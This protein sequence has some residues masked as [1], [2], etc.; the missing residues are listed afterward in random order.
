MDSQPSKSS[1]IVADSLLCTSPPTINGAVAMSRPHSFTSNSQFQTTNPSSQSASRLPV[2]RIKTAINPIAYSTKRVSNVRNLAQSLPDNDYFDVEADDEGENSG[3]R[4]CNDVPFDDE[5]DLDYQVIM[6]DGSKVKRAVSL[7]SVLSPPFIDALRPASSPSNTNV[8]IAPLL[9]NDSD[10]DNNADGISHPNITRRGRWIWNHVGDWMTLTPRKKNILKC[11]LAY[12][13]ASLFTFIPQLHALVGFSSHLAANATVFFKPMN[14]IGGITEAAGIGLIY[15]AC[16]VLVCIFSMVTAVYFNDHDQLLLGHLVT[17]IFWLGGSTFII[18]YLKARFDRPTVN[19][20]SSLACIILFIVLVK[21]GSWT[22]GQFTL[23]AIVGISSAVGAGA[24]ISIGVCRIVWPVHATEKLKKDINT[25]LNSFRILLKLLVK[26]FLLEL[27][28]QPLDSKNALASELKENRATFTALNKSLAEARLEFTN[29]AERRKMND[30]AEVVRSLQQLSNYMGGLRAS[31]GLQEKILK[32]RRPRRD[33]ESPSSSESSSEDEEDASSS[34]EPESETTGASSKKPTVNGDGEEAEEE[35]EEGTRLLFDFLR[36]VGGPMKAL[37]YTCKRTIVQLQVAIN[38]GDKHRGLSSFLPNHHSSQPEFSV[39]SFT[40]LKQNL[41]SALFLFEQEQRRE[42][43]KLYKRKW[44]YNRKAENIARP[45]EYVF[46]VYF[47]VFNLQEFAREL[48]QM[49]TKVEML[50]KNDDSQSTLYLSDE[51]GDS[52]TGHTYTPAPHPSIWRRAAG[53]ILPGCCSR[54]T[55]NYTPLRRH[56]WSDGI[57]QLRKRHG[58]ALIPANVTEQHWFQPMERNTMDTLHTP[59][60]R[61]VW[62]RFLLNIWSWLSYLRQFEVLFAFKCSVTAI[63]AAVPAFL[64]STRPIFREYRGEWAIITL[65]VVMTPTVGGTNLAAMYRVFGTL[66]GCYSAVIIYSLFPD[67]PVVLSLF[68]FLFA[69]P[70]FYVNLYTSHQKMG[71]FTLLAYNLVCLTKYNNREAEEEVEVELIAWRRF[72]AVSLGV[73]C[74]LLVTNYVWPYEARRELRKGLSEF[75][76]RIAWLYSK[77]V[78]VYSAP[79]A[80]LRSLSAFVDALEEHEDGESEA[81]SHHRRRR[82]R[83]HQIDLE[84]ARAALTRPTITDFVEMELALHRDLLRLFDLLALTPGEPR[85]KGP[86]PVSTYSQMLTSCQNI[87]DKLLCIRV[88]VTR[89]EWFL[90]VRRDFIIPVNKER[91]EM[92]GNVLLYLYVLSSAL[93]LKTP[94]PPYL[95]PARQSWRK[96]IHRIRSLPVVKKRVLLHDDQHYIFYYAYAVA[97]RDVIRELDNLGVKMGELFGVSPVKFDA[98]FGGED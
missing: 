96:L 92:V 49:I 75:L 32:G 48:L 82:R 37:A 38:T 5:E 84:T 2:R 9:T 47:Y 72:V 4:D 17:L 63:L 39:A 69:I 71:Q 61:T 60:P 89:E 25:S 31:C 90:S 58:S 16:A 21:E 50:F 23:K 22:L 40:K 93:H 51:E 10:S 7:S 18:S 1:N 41:K 66:I 33:S 56:N 73:V 80:P 59:L 67:N 36:H 52:E 54:S 81:R 26:T 29:C 78:S 6:D 79:S 91:K 86:F 65:M 42:V 11:A 98:Y 46:L 53:C 68:G 35:V 97:M 95:P 12:F 28:Y 15:G 77:L 55:Q 27:P 70:C 20:A 3:S 30:Y 85:L 62:R 13:L 14:T 19:T 74:G 64:H 44:R 87:L 76:H 43:A 83:R 24:L 88:V 8:S 57:K 34:D 45:S 94:L